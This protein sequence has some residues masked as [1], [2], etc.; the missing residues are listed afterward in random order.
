[1][2]ITTSARPWSSP[3]TWIVWLPLLVFELAVAAWRITKGVDPSTRK[4]AA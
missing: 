4:Q 3:V 2:T 1:M